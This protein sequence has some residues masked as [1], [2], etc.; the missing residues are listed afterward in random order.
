MWRRALTTVAVA[1]GAALAATSCAGAAQQPP[2]TDTAA[3]CGELPAA[4]TGT[5]EGWLGWIAAH[6]DDVTLVIDDG[7]GDVVAHRP[8]VQ[9]PSAS[10]SKVLHLAAYATAAAQGRL[11]PQQQV[12]IADWERWYVAGTDGGA[13]PRSLNFLQVPHD[14][15]RA[16]DP[17]RTVRL[18]D[19]ATVMIRFSDNAA[20]DLLRDRLGDPALRAAADAAGWRD[21]DLP[22]FSGQV[23]ALLRPELASPADLS[24]EE[25]AAV[26]LALGQRYAADEAFRAEI[27]AVPPPPPGRLLA[28]A[29]G[30]GTAPAA[31]LTALHRAIA[32]GS[33]GPGAE[34]ARRELEWQPP[35]PG[36]LG[37]G[38]KG[39][40]LPGVIA[41]AMTLRRADGSI[42]SA[43]LLAHR[44]P[45]ETWTTALQ[46]FAHQQLLIGAMTEPPMLDRV[47]CAA[48]GS[49]T[50]G[51]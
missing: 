24:R 17:Q 4:G 29:E 37:L 33:L 23:V 30:T 34:L 35:P 40:S 26:E 10:A 49:G 19:L 20:A 15:V 11:D 2:A 1:L 7:R 14:G 6:R 25:R 45:L 3:A 13:H 48:G 41:E 36:T 8:D 50:V 21:P 28:W 27:A 22:S 18:A 31:E 39:G 5:A 51:G 12:R 16:L 32:T 42:A 38:F 43:V 46:S 9:A 44:M 47:R